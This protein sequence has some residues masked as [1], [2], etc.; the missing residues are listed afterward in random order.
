MQLRLHGV[1]VLIHIP[2]ITQ[3]TFIQHTTYFHMHIHTLHIQ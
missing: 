2:T 3:K 1:H